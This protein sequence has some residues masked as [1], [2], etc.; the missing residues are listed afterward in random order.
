M[1]FDASIVT[2]FLFFAVAVAAASWGTKKILDWQKNE[3]TRRIDEG[4]REVRKQ[5]KLNQRDA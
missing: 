4:F 5:L 3:T 1:N 2:V